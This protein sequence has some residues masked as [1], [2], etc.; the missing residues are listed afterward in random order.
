MQSRD[1]VRAVRDWLSFDDSAGGRFKSCLPDQQPMNRTPRTRLTL[2]G[3]E[4]SSM[5]IIRFGLVALAAAIVLLPA[6]PA[7]ADNPCKN[8]GAEQQIRAQ[9]RQL[10]EQ[11]HAIERQYRGPR[12]RAARRAALAGI[13]QQLDALEAQQRSLKAQERACRHDRRPHHDRDHD[14]DRYR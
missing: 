11:R 5:A 1:L 10:E 7:S 9:H 4:D 3:Q 6:A 13:E 8:V 14:H 2:F 12:N